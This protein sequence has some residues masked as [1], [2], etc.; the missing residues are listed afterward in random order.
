IS[1]TT[2]VTLERMRC[3]SHRPVFLPSRSISPNPKQ[4]RIHFGHFITASC[5]ESA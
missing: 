2:E 4:R 1:V 5:H 3:L